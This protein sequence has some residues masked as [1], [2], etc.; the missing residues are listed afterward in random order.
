MTINA[1]IFVTLLIILFIFTRV[2]TR[3][4]LSAVMF[5]VISS[6]Y[7]YYFEL[8]F[9]TVG[10]PILYICILFIGGIL[11]SKKEVMPKLSLL[12]YYF[13]PLI[14]IHLLATDI[15]SYIITA[16]SVILFDYLYGE[17]IER[18]SLVTM[19]TILLLTFFAC[20]FFISTESDS[21][22]VFHVVSPVLFYLAYSF[23]ILA[24]VFWFSLKIDN[25]KST[26]SFSFVNLISFSVFMISI[27]RLGKTFWYELSPA[28]SELFFS[29]FA[30]MFVGIT[31]ISLLNSFY[32]SKTQTK[33]RSIFIFQLLVLFFVHLI[34][35]SMLDEG[36]IFRNIVI[37]CTGFY[38]LKDGVNW[39]T[40][41]MLSKG[42]LVFIYLS[43]IGIPLF[44]YSASYDLLIVGLVKNEMMIYTPIAVA[45]Y[46]LY[47]SHA[48]KAIV[49]DDLLMPR[50]LLGHT[51]PSKELLACGVIISTYCL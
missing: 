47:L 26:Q 49:I 32:S 20:F 10:K 7:W 48:I 1:S 40:S 36:I 14:L 29:L 42:L 2:F 34:D 37:L 45:L 44:M 51:F 30:L 22:N 15:F 50:P 17:K 16:I 12:L 21:L 41:A 31:T 24:W 23:F 28:Y 4:L 5:P 46:G 3:P 11:I 27:I 35:I 13:L 18:E 25:L 38:V 43:F 39:S 6:L 9:E 8:D 33:I 19:I